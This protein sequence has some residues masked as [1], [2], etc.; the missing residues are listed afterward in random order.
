MTTKRDTLW[1]ALLLFV[2]LGL[3]F[4]AWLWFNCAVRGWFTSMQDRGLYG[5]Q[6]GALNTLFSGLACGGI[7]FTL[8]LTYQQLRLQHREFEARTDSLQE[9]QQQL[10]QQ[11]RLLADQ[12]T[13]MTGPIHPMVDALASDEITQ[14][15]FDHAREALESEIEREYDNSKRQERLRKAF[16]AF[17][18]AAQSYIE[19]H[20]NMFHSLYHNPGATH[21]TAGSIK[22]TARHTEEIARLMADWA[23]NIREN[24]EL[25]A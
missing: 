6:F 12:L 8:Y 13:E 11:T 15:L 5:D 22:S 20:S 19:A 17:V 18:P 1:N 2:C 24:R 21:A 4:G 9:G 10:A 16:D 23:K 25:N 3:P 7:V 14:K